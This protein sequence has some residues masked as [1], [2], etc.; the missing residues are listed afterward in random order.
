[1]IPRVIHYCWFGRNPLPKQVRD[2]IATWHKYCPEYEIKEWNEDN[3]NI[4]CNRYVYEAYKARKFAFVSDFARLY[5]LYNEGG[6]YLDT[7]VEVR[8]TFDPFLRNKSFIGWEDN[9]LGTGVL[10]ATKGTQWV[11]NIMDSYISEPFIYWTGKLNSYPNPYRLNKV[12]KCYGL[13]MNHQYDILDDDIAI[14]PIEILCANNHEKDELCIGE[15]TV[16]IHYY[17][18]TWSDK[19]LSIFK[20]ITNRFK[21]LYIK[22]YTYIGL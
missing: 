14:Y 11:K 13:K 21:Y 10:A 2:Y 19:H 18:G 15:N 16:C 20:K 9:Y 8:K 22:I 17:A 6:I 3:F 12:M 5:A 1:M 4:H 7:D